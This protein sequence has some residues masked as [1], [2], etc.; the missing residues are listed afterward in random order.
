MIQKALSDCPAGVGHLREL[1]SNQAAEA[2]YAVF[3]ALKGVDV[4]F[5]ALHGQS[6]DHVR[7]EGFNFP[8]MLIFPEQSRPY[9]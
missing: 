5:K 2:S 7:K 8:T 1:L 6:E 3:V 9:S 4:M